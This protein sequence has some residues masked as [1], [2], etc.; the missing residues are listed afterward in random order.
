[1]FWIICGLIAAGIFLYTA[2]DKAEEITMLDLLV[3][4]V[5]TILGWISLIIAAGFLIL[6]PDEIN[7]AERLKSY[8]IYEK[9]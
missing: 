5:I 3:A 9:D 8:V 7:W 1:M 4:I 6:T 2:Y